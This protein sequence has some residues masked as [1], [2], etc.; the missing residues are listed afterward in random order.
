[1]FYYVYITYVIPCMILLY[2]WDWIFLCV[3]DGIKNCVC[4]TH[5]IVWDA[6][7]EEKKQW[8]HKGILKITDDLNNN[9]SSLRVTSV[10]QLINSQPTVN[11]LQLIIGQPT[12]NDLQLI[13]GQ[14]TTN[15]LQLI[16]SQPT[17]NDLTNISS[18]S[19][20]VLKLLPWTGCSPENRM[21][22]VV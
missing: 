1:M 5:F 14:P 8:F 17:M 10:F 21:C 4:I 7:F 2:M 9:A 19:Q 20:F 3:F 11:D 12:K 22:C 16:T 15:D 18:S 13:I 6:V